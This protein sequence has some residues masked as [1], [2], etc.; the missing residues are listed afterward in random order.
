VV[1]DPKVTKI[2]NIEIP[3]ERSPFYDAILLQKNLKTKNF[4]T[5][6]SILYLYGIQKRKT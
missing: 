6:K 5:I 1:D 4:S 2:E 3:S